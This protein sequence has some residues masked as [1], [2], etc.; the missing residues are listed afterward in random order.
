[1]RIAF[2]HEGRSSIRGIDI[3]TVEK[4]GCDVV[5]TLWYNTMMHKDTYDIQIG[6]QTMQFEFNDLAAYANGSVIARLGETTVMAVVTMGKQSQYD[7]GGFPLRVD[8]QERNYARGAILGSQYNKREGKPTDEAVLTSRVIDRTI[9]PFFPEGFNYEVQVV[10][11]VLALGDYDP[12]VLAI[13]AA[14]LALQTSDIPWNGPVA[15]VRVSENML[16]TG[17]TV[18]R[19]V[20]VNPTYVERKQDTNYHNTIVSG[21]LDTIVMMETEAT[22]VS[23]EDM[24][25][26]C[27]VAGDSINR[28]CEFFTGLVKQHGKTKIE[29]ETATYSLDTE[30]L[31]AEQLEPQVRASLGRIQDL[32]VVSFWVTELTR[33]VRSVDSG[34]KENMAVFITGKIKEIV[35]ESILQHGERIDGRAVDAVR[36]VYAQ[37]G[38][39][40]SRLHGTGI[41]Y[42]GETRVLS[43]LTLG[44]LDD[45]QMFHEMEIDGT[46][47]WM[48]H[49]NFPPYSV[50]EAGRMGSPGRREIGHGTLAEKSLIRMLPAESVFP[51]TIRV[52][53]EVMSS[54]G[55]T[56]MA[57]TAAATI[58]LLDGGVPL[59]KPV[60]GVAMGM[61]SDEHNHVLLTDILGK[62]DYYGDMD[63]K[64]SGTS[65][66]ITAIQ[67]DCKTHGISLDI[68]AETL[69]RS[70]EAR[71]QILDAITDVISAPHEMSSYVERITI[72]Q[73]PVG[74]IGLVI[75]KGGVTIK[76]ITAESGAK[77]DIKRD[78]SAFITGNGDAPVHAQTLINQILEHSD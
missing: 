25:D 22:E 65:D 5:A 29:F 3:Q 38:G 2:G 39:V 63:F 66:G 70:H 64:V 48:H 42:R 44:S 23:N 40:A 50:G 61:V 53:S 69:D 57:A 55:S 26:V 18:E 14:C 71:R 33:I 73:I 77:I 60:A 27:R 32:S 78:G 62:E 45:E 19:A 28:L 20:M 74:K 54:N 17:D 72:V 58:A 16:I 43:V 21:A 76:Q 12:D 59:K 49:Y 51:Y 13:N 56:S 7:D 34:N 6:G 41:F 46:K 11:T 1:M 9:R 15:C 4:M 67:L 75:G 35:R 52:V 47:R 68:I 36:D 8:Y 31:F 30:R 37:A 10:V 24:V